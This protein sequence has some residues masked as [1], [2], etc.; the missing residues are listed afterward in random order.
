MHQ[1]FVTKPPY[2]WGRAGDGRAKLGAVQLLFDCPCS[3]G[4]VPEFSYME[5]FPSEI[6]CYVGTKSRVVTISLSS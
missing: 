1:S 3:A 5:S 6:F 4:E 2:L